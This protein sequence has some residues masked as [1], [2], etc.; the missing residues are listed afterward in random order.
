MEERLHEIEEQRVPE[1]FCNLAFGGIV[2]PTQNQTIGTV[3]TRLNQIIGG[4][5]E[6][7]SMRTALAPSFILSEDMPGGIS[8]PARV[9]AQ[10]RLARYYSSTEDDL[11]Q[12]VAIPM[13]L[14]LRDLHL[15]GTDPKAVEE[16]SQVFE[17]LEIEALCQDWW[18]C[19]EVYG[20]AYPFEVWDG[21]APVNVSTL[22]PEHVIIDRPSTFG[23]SGFSLS[24]G[25]RSL[26]DDFKEHK[27]PQSVWNSFENG[28]ADKT[29]LRFKDGAVSQIR[30]RAPSFELYVTP[31]LTRSFRTLS[32]R[33]VLEE[34]IRAT[35]E[36]FKNQLW[37]FTLEDPAPGEISH[38][39][40]TLSG[41][42]GERT[43][44]IVW[45]GNLKVEQHAPK[46]LDSMLANEKWLSLTQDIMR[47]RGI[48]M[49]LMG[50]EKG[51]T[52]D[53]DVKV[54][55]ER[56]SFQ[57]KQIL[58]Y[59]KT[60]IAKYAKLNGMKSPPSPVF[61][62]VALEIED[63][64][65]NRVVPLYRVGLLSPQTSLQVAGHDYDNE[66]RLKKANQKYQDLFSPAPTFAQTTVNPKTPEKTSAFDPGNGRPADQSG[67]DKQKMKGSWAS[68]VQSA[69]AVYEATGEAEP[70]IAQMRTLNGQHMRAAYA[71]G[72]TAAGGD[73]EPDA[74]RAAAVTAWN[75]SFL[76]GF[77][78]NL[79]ARSPEERSGASFRS[80][81][82]PREGYRM[83]YAYG[84]FQARKEQGYSHWKRV[85]QPG[86][87][88]A[89]YD[90]SMTQHSLGEEF[91]EP[92]PAGKCGQTFL[93]FSRGEMSSMP[94]VLPNPGIDS[95]MGRLRTPSRS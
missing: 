39:K 72:Y 87:C 20:Q 81:L 86:A 22:N 45:K 93:V 17:A 53:I 82:Y 67:E 5:T 44:Y 66:L 6:V 57:R 63:L 19:L 4:V 79:Q 23:S 51:P 84:A 26:Q 70:F 65:K 94:F 9:L 12:T 95:E 59:L 3:A 50:Y 7:S 85:I 33:Q 62:K 2:E 68:E 71:E 80:S 14:G 92:H 16:I 61:E 60:F 34:L 73:S 58:R 54:L 88:E 47:G 32:T 42:N 64:I 78:A 25:A 40:S 11:Y 77:A 21:K 74:S 89:C 27:I 18:Y 37:V 49:K 69:F 48:S 52:S 35:I 31:P 76:A 29:I 8:P 38:L 10:M 1:E 30:G 46:T 13:D 43:G 36:G 15:E 83:A 28:V 55:V 56:L 91:F 41:L 75:D 90:D 24:L